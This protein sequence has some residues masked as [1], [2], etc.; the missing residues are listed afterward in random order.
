M[1]C[2]NTTMIGKTISHYRIIEELGRGGMG[3]VYKAEDTKLKRIVALKFLPPELTHNKESKERFIREAHAAS[4]LE[5][6]NICT[7]HEIDETD[8]GQLFIVMACYEGLSLRD[9]IKEK[10]QKT[11]DVIEYMIQIAK[12]L[13][14]A[15]DK[16]I[17]HRDIKPANIFITDDGS[18]KILDFGL[19]KLAGQAQLTKDSS[20]L[21]TVAYMSPEQLSGKDVDQRTDIW[22]LGVILYEML[23]G[24]PPFKG[25]YEQA[26][27]YSILNDEP[28][29][30]KDIDPNIEK[31]INICLNKD[32]KDRYQSI[33][34]LNE[35][36]LKLKNNF[37]NI[38]EK[39]KV[40]VVNRYKPFILAVTLFILLIFILIG[41]FI[42]HQPDNFE[43]TN[44]TQP[45]WEN[46]IAVLPFVDM[47]PT[48]DQEYFCDGLSEEI[49]NKLS[50]VKSLK[51]IART[52]SFQFKDK[53]IDAIE[54]GKKLNVTNILEGSVR[55]SNN[56]VRI[57]AQLINTEDGSHLWSKTYDKEMK[58]IFSIQDEIALSI[59][60]KIKI[61][62]IGEDNLIRVGTNNIDAYEA[63]LQG[64]FFFQK[65][66]P[67]DQQKA[68]EY[69]NKS[70]EIDPLF[71][72]AY[73]GLAD[74]YN[75][76][77]MSGVNPPLENIPKAREMV[78]KA[79]ELDPDLSEAYMIIAD[80][81]NTYERD[82]KEAEELYKKSI[83][84]N[85]GNATAH[86]YFGMF[87]MSLTRYD[88][89]LLEVKKSIKLDPL[90]FV[91]N[92]NGYYLSLFAQDE[93]LTKQTTQKL[94]ILNPDSS[95]IRL[96][97]A[98][99]YFYQEKYD[100][101]LRILSGN[102]DQ[103]IEDGVTTFL[104][105]TYA[106]SGNIDKAREILSHLLTRKKNKYIDPFRIATIYAV[107]EDKDKAFE[108]LNK[109]AN[110]FSPRIS[111]I[112]CFPEFEP[113]RDDQRYIELLKKLGIK[114]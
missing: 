101:V 104:A 96:A 35:D 51:V 49:I 79:L 100:D 43:S 26:I 42:F 71:A 68:I 95:D 72:K 40:K 57:T 1:Y 19:A 5:H 25:D 98:T 85:P 2:W 83:Q 44:A 50:S 39:N 80:I 105:C 87:L 110:E 18:V 15:H 93:Q 28:K 69:Y 60:D 102:T 64:Q 99:D 29:I 52:S 112:Q 27:T 113:I 89:A 108:W 54:I 12:G 78:S 114:P 62:M 47:S 66:T 48:K 14:K 84:L 21:G 91:L 23:T 41:Y 94:L 67:D 6:D 59:L 3:L 88:E 7:I 109:S 30:I 106:R 38:A 86:S 11:K 53:L 107:L 58:N 70:I 16:G 17:I 9:K 75:N 90:S 34:G 46:S 56:M 13:Q 63:Y 4:A 81:K 82:K 103:G 31:I 74:V 37:D 76:L 36:L 65:F 97:L 92:M 77:S 32:S 24:E 22:S 8:D 111:Y 33:D 20:T 55:K 45:E 73:A 61:G 10:R